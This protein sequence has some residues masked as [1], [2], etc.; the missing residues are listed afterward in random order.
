MVAQRFLAPFVGVRVPT[1][2][3]LTNMFRPDWADRKMAELA[4][5]L[6]PSVPP[7]FASGFC[8]AIRRERRACKFA[9][10]PLILG[11]PQKP[12]TARNSRA[13][14]HEHCAVRQ[15][16]NR[17]QGAICRARKREMN[18]PTR[19]SANIRKDITPRAG[20]P[21]LAKPIFACANARLAAQNNRYR[22]GG[23][24]D[25]R[26]APRGLKPSRAGASLSW[27]VFPR[28]LFFFRIFADA[29]A[30]ARVFE[31]DA[32]H[33]FGLPFS[34]SICRRRFLPAI[35]RR[36]SGEKP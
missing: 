22:R 15:E 2:Q 25:R 29:Q 34:V 24:P 13:D 12:A 6:P 14:I 19:K 18:F 35:S 26:A 33:K 9:C 1:G 7:F 28:A 21:P 17:K 30:R 16:G 23:A 3:R 4:R 11:E 32:L 8:R 36:N 10:L 31:R 27:T 5:C 20:R